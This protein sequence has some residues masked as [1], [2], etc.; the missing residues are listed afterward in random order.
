MDIITSSKIA[1]HTW[2]HWNLTSLSFNQIHDEMWRVEQAL[3]R[4]IGVT[5]AFMRPPYGS[6]NDLVR[7]VSAERGQDLV[8]WDFDSRDSLGATAAESEAL[9]DRLAKD[10]PSTVIALNHETY[11]ELPTW[12]PGHRSFLFMSLF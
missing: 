10:H 8:I 6:Y 5:P 9:Y 11:G 4:M 2:H 7:Q 1:S 12:A 3:Q